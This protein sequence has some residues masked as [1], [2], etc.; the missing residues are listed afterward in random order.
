L[1][2]RTD[3]SCFVIGNSHGCH[4][5]LFVRTA[6][7]L[8]DAAF[9][10]QT[11]IFNVD[12]F[13]SFESSLTAYTTHVTRCTEREVRARAKADWKSQEARCRNM[14][15]CLDA[16]HVLDCGHTDD[17][18]C[19]A[20]AA[21]AAQSDDSEDGSSD[22]SDD[23]GSDASSGDDDDDDD[24]AEKPASSKRAKLNSGEAGERSREGARGKKKP[25]AP[26]PPSVSCLKR[27]ISTLECLKLI[28]HRDAS[29]MT[30]SFCVLLLRSICY[31]LWL[32]DRCWKPNCAACRPSARWHA[33]HFN[34]PNHHYS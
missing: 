5:R 21:L 30:G 14:L 17:A 33:R 3:S 16:C 19:A 18:A 2:P 24:D 34:Q 12:I 6:Q 11:S 15:A 1:H 13:K 29:F 22:V 10:L 31:A 4:W 32:R 9:V 27:L 25:K 28:V 23:D 20:G 26:V 7:V 8:V